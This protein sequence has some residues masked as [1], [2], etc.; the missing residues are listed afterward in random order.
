MEPIGLEEVVG[1]SDRLYVTR[2]EAG[3]L[4]EFADHRVGW[5]FAGVH[6]PTGE[7]IGSCAMSAAPPSKKNPAAL[8]NDR[9]GTRKGPFGGW[10]TTCT[11]PASSTGS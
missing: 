5:L 9:A 1:P 11:R 3:L 8:K 2:D 6:L 4:S 10:P 7:G